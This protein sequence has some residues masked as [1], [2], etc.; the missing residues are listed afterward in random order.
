MALIPPIFLDAVVAVGFAG[1]DGKRTYQATGFIYGHFQKQVDE[2]KKVYLTY[3]VT[4][5]HVF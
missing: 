1:D 5:R 2:T 3:L 4:N